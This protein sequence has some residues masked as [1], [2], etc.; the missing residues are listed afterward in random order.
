MQLYV[1]FCHSK[2]ITTP[3]SLFPHRPIFF[4]DLILMKAI[5]GTE[6][7]SG[8]MDRFYGLDACEIRTITEAGNR[9]LTLLRIAVTSRHVTWARIEPTCRKSSNQF[10]RGQW[11]RLKTPF[12]RQIRKHKIGEWPKRKNKQSHL[13]QNKLKL[14]QDTQEYYQQDT[15][16][17]IIKILLAIN[18]FYQDVVKRIIFKTKNVF[19]RLDMNLK[20]DSCKFIVI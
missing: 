17:Y 7:F 9:P 6:Q 4:L 13:Q 1:G 2:C 12:R 5:S 19:L 8:S 10:S 11:A 15:Q 16:E 18:V 14:Q 20:S 3:F